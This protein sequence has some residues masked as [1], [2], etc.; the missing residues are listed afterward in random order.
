MEQLLDLP[1]PEY[2]KAVPGLGPCQRIK[3]I[4]VVFLDDLARM[5]LTSFCAKDEPHLKDMDE[6]GL[7]PVLRERLARARA[8]EQARSR[9][10]A[11]MRLW[12]VLKDAMF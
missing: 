10:P 3:G 2:P 11:R 1:G 12:C 4:R 8:R 9:R 6:A 5:K 7:S